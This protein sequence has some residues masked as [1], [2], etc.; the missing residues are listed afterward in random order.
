M[1]R[2]GSI[3]EFETGGSLNSS[4]AIGS[5]GTVYIGSDDNKL[6]AINGKTGVKLWDFETRG[7]V[8]SSP[9]IGSDGTVYIGS[10]DKKL[11]AIKTNSKGLA[12][13]PWPMF[14]QNPQHTSRVPEPKPCGCRPAK[15]WLGRWGSTKNPLIVFTPEKL[16]PSS[17]RSSVNRIRPKVNFGHIP[18]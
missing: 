18:A 6:Y 1:A 10:V 2:L 11:Y 12:N 9:A 8:H 7:K 13:S 15:L 3:W 17:S 5:D 14:G 16:R 4:P